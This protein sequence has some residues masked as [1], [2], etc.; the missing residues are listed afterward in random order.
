MKKLWIGLGIGLFWIT[1]PLLMIYLR[2]KMRARIMLTCGD[3]VL[4]VKGW[5]S[6]GRWT[7]P[8]GGLHKNE[9]ITMG[10][11]RELAEETGIAPDAASVKNMGKFHHHHRGLD[12]RY[13]LLTTELKKEVP[14]KIKRREIVAAQWMSR[15]DLNEANAQQHVLQALAAVKE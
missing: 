8:G 14:P 2:L 1:L 15:S 3:K 11:L 12:Y 13:Y 5:Q 10:V 9:D 4:V 7:L 6:D